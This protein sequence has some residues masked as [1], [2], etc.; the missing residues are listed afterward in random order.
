MDCRAVSLIKTLHRAEDSYIRFH[1]KTKEGKSE[2]LFSIRVSHLTTHLPPRLQDLSKDGYFS[3]NGYWHPSLQEGNQVLPIVRFFSRTV[4]YLR[5]L[6]A[7]C[8]DIKCDDKPGLVDG[9][10]ACVRRLIK[11][12]S[13]PP[14]SCILVSRDVWLFWILRSEKEPSKPPPADRNNLAMYLQIEKT[15]GDLVRELGIDPQASEAAHVTRLLDWV[16]WQND[17]TVRVL[18]PTPMPPRSYTLQ[19]LVNFLDSKNPKETVLLNNDWKH[20]IL[21]SAK[22]HGVLVPKPHERNPWTKVNQRRLD[23]FLTLWMIRGEFGQGCRNRAALIY[24]R[25]LTMVG[26]SLPEVKT[27]VEVLAETCKPPLESTQ[28]AEAVRAGTDRRMKAINETTTSAWLSITSDEHLALKDRFG[29]YAWNRARGEPKPPSKAQE[30]RK[31]IERIIVESGPQSCR[32]MHDLLREKGHT[33]SLWQVKTDYR[34]LKI[35]PAGRER[36]KKGGRARS[37]H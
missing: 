14:P 12:G 27:H 13:V 34:I 36:R 37:P 26:F 31:A 1:R 23:Q 6:N 28:V 3:I 19:G 15:I 25:L 8:V 21:E 11:D 2:N 32:R 24:A 9:V 33:T 22:W 10:R 20:A 7:I 18:W 35:A 30:R 5:Y 16:I 17:R 4:K 29:V